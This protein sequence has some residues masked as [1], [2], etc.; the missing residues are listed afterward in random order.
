MPLDTGVI[1]VKL[2]LVEQEIRTQRH[3]LL[4]MRISHT[5]YYGHSVRVLFR[6][7]S[8]AY[9][10][11]KNSCQHIVRLISAMCNR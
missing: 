2:T 10:G 6:D 3:S 11:E 7:F 9:R 5:Q 8:A 1:P 4:I